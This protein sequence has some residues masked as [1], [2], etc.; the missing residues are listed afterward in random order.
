MSAKTCFVKLWD[1]CKNK[2]CLCLGLVWV[3][4][5]YLGPG[6]L[7]LLEFIDDFNQHREEEGRKRT[8]ARVLY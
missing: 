6:R 7:A 3:A 5:I 2:T 1:G 4:F 8:K